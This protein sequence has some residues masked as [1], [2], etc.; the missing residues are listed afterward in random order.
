MRTPKRQKGNKHILFSRAYFEKM[1]KSEL[2][3]NLFSWQ[4]DILKECS[5]IKVSL[6]INDIIMIDK[7]CHIL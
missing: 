3:F 2:V 1:P 5:N 4:L 7:F 6:Y